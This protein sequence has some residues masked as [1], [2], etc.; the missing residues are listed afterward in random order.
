VLSY[1]QRKAGA[2]YNLAG[3]HNVYAIGADYIAL[4][5]KGLEN[6]GSAFK[7]NAKLSTFWNPS[8]NKRPGM[9]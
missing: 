7:T 2:I 4:P 5:R 3:D 6:Q 1:L 8:L 9:T